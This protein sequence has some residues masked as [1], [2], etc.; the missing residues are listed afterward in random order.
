LSLDGARKVE[1][2]KVLPVEMVTNIGMHAA[3]ELL[4]NGGKEIAD[5]IRHAEK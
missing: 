5:S 4:E 1:V 3:E 2:E